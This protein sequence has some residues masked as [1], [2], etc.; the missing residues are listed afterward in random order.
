MPLP[1]NDA[2]DERLQNLKA[3]WHDYC[4]HG[5]FEQFVEFAVAVSSLAEQFNRLKLP[6]M[7]RLCQ[8]LENVVLAHLDGRHDVLMSEQDRSALARQLNT[9]FAAVQGARTPV[10]ERR[11]PAKPSASGDTNWVKPRIVWVVADKGSE[12]AAGLARQLAFFGFSAEAM[13][14]SVATAQ[15]GSPL[16]IVL[17]PSRNH[18]RKA[19]LP[20]I[21]A[22]RTRCRASQIF[23]LGVETA[24]EAI[25]ELMRAG[26]DFAVPRS[27]PISSVINRV[28]DLTQAENAERYRVLIV[29][30]SR[31]AAAMARRTL[32]EHGIDS[33]PIHDPAEMLEALADYRPDLILMDMHMPRFSG[34]E[35]TRVLR[36]STAYQTVP[37]VYLSGESDVGM[38]IE[39]LRLGGDQFLTKPFNPVLLAAVVKTKIERFRE[40]QRSTT[41]DGLTGLLNHTASKARLQTLVA[42]CPPGTPLSV[43]MIDIDHFKAVNDTY[44]HPVGDQVIRGLAWLLKGR[45]RTSDLIGRYGGEEFAVIFPRE[46]AGAVE[47]ALNAAREEIASRSLRRRS[48]NDDLGAAV[49]CLLVERVDATLAGIKE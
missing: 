36:Q 41:L 44:G 20:M 34:I 19:S 14:W 27:E 7:V 6:G 32:A 40:M 12:P 26:V 45:L 43:A 22:L 33:H 10:S 35:A 8:G 46:T 13:E 3:R 39:A 25:V 49:A 2:L 5:D 11:H 48:T 15:E 18:D 1:T 38:Q 42:Q 30:D 28:L 17:M 4:Q 37:V 21:E 9:L 16:A 31:V 23:Y 24:I 47:A 29:E